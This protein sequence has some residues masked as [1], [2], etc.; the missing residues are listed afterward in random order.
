MKPQ[1]PL[2]PESALHPNTPYQQLRPMLEAYKNQVQAHYN[3]LQHYTA[4]GK[5]HWGTPEVPAS[6]SD[7]DL[8][9]ELAKLSP[10][11]RAKIQVKPT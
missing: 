2:F 11:A 5:E 3:S 4:N 7:T 9:A 8:N 1:M 10:A 6:I